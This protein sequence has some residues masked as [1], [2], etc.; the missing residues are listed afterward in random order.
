MEQNKNTENSPVSIE[1]SILELEK[2]V[3]ELENGERDLDTAFSLFERA[4][5]LSKGLRSELTSYERKIQVITGS[6]DESGN[7]ILQPFAE[8]HESKRF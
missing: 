6:V 2:I 7:S 3:R 8:E 5:T 4:V 1:S